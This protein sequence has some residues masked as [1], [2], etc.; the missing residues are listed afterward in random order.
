MHFST[1]RC[2]CSVQ[3]DKHGLTKGLKTTQSI[4]TSNVRQPRQLQGC[5]RPLRIASTAPGQHRLRIHSAGPIACSMDHHQKSAWHDGQYVP[6]AADPPAADRPHR[7]SRRDIAPERGGYT[8]AGGR[9]SQMM[10]RKSRVIVI[11]RCR[12]TKAGT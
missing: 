8:H 2:Y 1:C 12:R 6:L 4:S 5:D 10:F 11:R 3:V 9:S 7:S